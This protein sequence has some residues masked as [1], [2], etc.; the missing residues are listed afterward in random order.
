[1][2]YFGSQFQKTFLNFYVPSKALKGRIKLGM[3][4]IG[5]VDNLAIELSLCVYFPLFPKVLKKGIFALQVMWSLQ[6]VIY[7]TIYCFRLSKDRKRIIGAICGLG[8]MESS[9][10]PILPEH[11]ME[12]T[13]DVE[14]T[15]NDVQMVCTCFFFYQSSFSY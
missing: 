14:F 5:V 15:L 11:D 12:V 10:V 8:Y 2:V 1:M 13:F 9:N 6:Y 7:A 4:N 3:A